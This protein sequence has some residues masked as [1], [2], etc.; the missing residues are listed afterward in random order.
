MRWTIGRRLAAIGALSIVAVVT[1]GTIGWTQASGSKARADRAFTVAK[2]LP[3][4]I[5]AQHTASG[6][7]ADAALLATTEL[8]KEKRVQ[9][10]DELIEQAQELRGRLELIR[11]ITIDAQYAANLSKLV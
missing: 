2:A 8:T 9:L 1:V 7:L 10:V 6:V 5:D 4:P 11:G 3:A